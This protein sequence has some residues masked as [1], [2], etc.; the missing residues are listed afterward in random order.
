MNRLFAIRFDISREIGTG[1]ATRALAFGAELEKRNLPYFY[2]TDIG[3]VDF[4]KSI[5]VS[6]SKLHGFDADAGEAEWIKR[7]A[8]VTHVIA[9][10]CHS[11]HIDSGETVCRILQAKELHVTVIDSMPPYHYR[12]KSNAIPSVVITPYFGAEFLCKKPRCCKWLSGAQYAILEKSIV[13]ERY[14]LNQKNSQPGKYILLCFGG[15]DPG[16]LSPLVL[17]KILE[18]GVPKFDIKVVIGT[19]F[20]RKLTNELEHLARKAPNSITLE[21]GKNGLARLIADCSFFIGTVGIVRYELACLGKKMFLVQKNS[22]YDSYLRGFEKAGLSK[23]YLL[24]HAADR[25]RFD[26]MIEN[27]HNDEFIRLHSEFNQCGFDLV[28]GQGTVKCIDAV[29]GLPQRYEIG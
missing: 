1:H 16:Q 20:D 25:N 26:T 19:L 14:C 6:P 3:G 9:D 8:D 24:N 29:L 4:A 23:V 27:L 18:H 11:R 17:R 2:V 12:G 10:F 7:N 15:S 22:D 5:G 13:S 28:D 21:S